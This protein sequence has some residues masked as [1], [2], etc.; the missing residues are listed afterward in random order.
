MAA[1]FL[2]LFKHGISTATVATLGTTGYHS[3]EASN[4]QLDFLRAMMTP[5]V[6]DGSVYGIDALLERWRLYS[7]YHSNLDIELERLEM[8]A[9]NTVIATTRVSM[10]ITE[11]TLYHAFRHLFNGNASH[12]ERLVAKL[13]GQHVTMSGS[14]RFGWDDTCGRVHSL[15]HSADML[16]PM[17]KLLGN[18][19]DVAFV[20][21][22]ARITPDDNVLRDEQMLWSQDKRRTRVGC[23]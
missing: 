3:L 11:S 15:E 5:D 2:G 20:F 12:S 17:L 18:L 7:L 4:A 21:S 13:L 22:R 1:E 6:T 23:S 14:V 9:P 10:T 8:G 16:T 19:E